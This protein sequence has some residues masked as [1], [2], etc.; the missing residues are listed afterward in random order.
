[1]SRSSGRSRR[2]TTAGAWRP[3]LAF[4]RSP[5]FFYIA[6]LYLFATIGLVLGPLGIGIPLMLPLWL[7]GLV[8]LYPMCRGYDGFKSSRPPESLWRLL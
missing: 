5:L 2:A 1:M 7:L 3:L 6:H 8:A 4:G